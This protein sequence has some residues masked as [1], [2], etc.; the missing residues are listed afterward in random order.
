[1][2]QRNTRTPNKHTI[3]QVSIL[4][5]EKDKKQS[6]NKSKDEDVFI[7]GQAY[8]MDLAFVSGLSKLDNICTTS[9]ESVTVKQRRDRYI[10]FLIIINI[11]SRQ[12]WTHLI[13]NK[14][15][16]DYS[17][18]PFCDDATEAVVFTS[19]PWEFSVRLTSC[20]TDSLPPPSVVIVA[21]LDRKVGCE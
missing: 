17:T 16:W 20:D 21:L 1:M 8:H 15:M 13:E 6:G 3:F 10:G 5:K 18:I 4:S 14:V 12:L 7:L 11:A 2:Y 19:Y 9:E